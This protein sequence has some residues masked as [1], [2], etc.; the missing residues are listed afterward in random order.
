MVLGYKDLSNSTIEKYVHILKKDKAYL[1]RNFYKS[2]SLRTHILLYK[3]MSNQIYFITFYI[4]KT[5]ISYYI[6]IYVYF[7]LNITKYMQLVIFKA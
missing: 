6:Y 3:L 7:I 4:Y 5:F 1:Q 2:L